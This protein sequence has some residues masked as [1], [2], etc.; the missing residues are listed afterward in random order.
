[1]DNHITLFIYPEIKKTSTLA[2]KQ[3]EGPTRQVEISLFVIG[4]NV[5][6]GGFPVRYLMRGMT[7][8]TKHPDLSISY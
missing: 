8:L 7:I 2:D 3:S 6:V 4:P 1:M 5:S